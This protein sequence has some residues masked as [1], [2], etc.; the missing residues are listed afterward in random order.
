VWKKRKVSRQGMGGMKKQRR[1]L[2]HY[3]VFLC[4][5]DLSVLGCDDVSFVSGSWHLKG[6]EFLYLQRSNSTIIRILLGVL[7]SE[8]DPL[9]C[10]K[11]CLTK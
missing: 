3:S 8:D 11:H 7:G 9:K 10:Q 5:E 2:T 1:N 6:S 4:D